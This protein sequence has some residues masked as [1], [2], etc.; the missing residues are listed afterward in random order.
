MTGVNTRRQLE[1]SRSFHNTMMIE[2]ALKDSR[3]LEQIHRQHVHQLDAELKRLERDMN[4]HNH[5]FQDEVEGVP[6]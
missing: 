3:S 6:I 4:W 2:A 5:N 1:A